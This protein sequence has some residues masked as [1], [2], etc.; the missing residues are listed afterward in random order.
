MPRKSYKKEVFVAVEKLQKDGA[1]IEVCSNHLGIRF[2]TR[3][4]AHHISVKRMT[5]KE[6]LMWLD[7][8]EVA[9]RIARGESVSVWP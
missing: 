6:A 2:D 9:R 5:P 7:G 4:L 8:Y 3:G 1:D